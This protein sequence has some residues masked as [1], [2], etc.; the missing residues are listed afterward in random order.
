MTGAPI[1]PGIDQR[2]LTEAHLSRLIEIVVEVRM[3]IEVPDPDSDRD[4]ARA[5]ERDVYSACNAKPGL[6]G[7]VDAEAMSWDEVRDG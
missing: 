2:N 5:V 4:V 3:Q 7:H 1:T 6:K